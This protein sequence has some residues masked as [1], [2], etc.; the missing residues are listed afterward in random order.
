VEKYGGA[1]EA[2][3]NDM[4]GACWINKTTCAEAHFH[5]R[6]RMHTHTHTH[7]RKKYVMVIAFPR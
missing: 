5:A 7:T 4:R 3:D 6:A 1:R 2:E